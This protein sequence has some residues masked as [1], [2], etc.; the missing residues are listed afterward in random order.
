MPA[1]TDQNLLLAPYCEIGAMGSVNFGNSWVVAQQGL[2][3]VNIFG[4]TEGPQ[5]D[6]FVAVTQQNVVKCNDDRIATSNW[7]P[8]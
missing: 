4:V 8:W 6:D 2:T 5:D 3:G 1:P 7:T